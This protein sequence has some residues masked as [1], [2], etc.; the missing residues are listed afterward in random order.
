MFRRNVTADNETSYE[1]KVLNIIDSNVL[2]IETLGLLRCKP[3]K[4]FGFISSGRT[5]ISLIKGKIF[6]FQNATFYK[7]IFCDSAL[8]Y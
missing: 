5:V 3:E 8:N 2:Q 7:N 4:D 1:K 6:N